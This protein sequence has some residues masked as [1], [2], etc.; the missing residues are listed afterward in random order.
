VSKAVSDEIMAD[1][2]LVARQALRRTDWDGSDLDHFVQ[3]LC[4]LDADRHGFGALDLL[5][6]EGA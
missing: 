3:V 5:T 2:I 1:K 6:V 4:R